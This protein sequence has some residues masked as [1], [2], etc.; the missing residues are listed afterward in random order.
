MQAALISGFT[1]WECPNCGIEERTGPVPPNAGRFHNCARLHFLVAPLVR[2]GTRCKVWAGLR[3]D[4]QGRELTQDGDDGKP[5][6]QVVTTRDDGQ[7][8]AVLA[9]CAQ[10]YG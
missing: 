1:D 5:Y 10:F 2:K 9:P 3:E 8:V 7:D 4:Y 6:M